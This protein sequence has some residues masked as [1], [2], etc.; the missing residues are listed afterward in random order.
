MKN[1]IT[2]KSREDL[3]NKMAVVFGGNTKTLSP[4]LQNVLLDDLVTALENRLKILNGTY[5]N[6]QL[7]TAIIE[8][9]KCETIE[10]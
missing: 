7:M 8:S 1:Q 6:T 3:K 10:T 2:A 4:D 5:Q 9:A